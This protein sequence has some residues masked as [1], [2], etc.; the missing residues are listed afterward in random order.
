VQLWFVNSSPELCSNVNVCAF[1]GKFV[2]LFLLCFKTKNTAGSAIQKLHPRQCKTKR[3]TAGS[4]G[5]LR[6][7]EAVQKNMYTAGR[8]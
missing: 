1:A 5:S 7:S 3:N 8:A 4:Q 2:L 6:Q